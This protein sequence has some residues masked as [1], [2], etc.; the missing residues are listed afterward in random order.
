MNC[1]PRPVR[2]PDFDSLITRVRA[3]YEEMP[4][5][6]LTIPQL[7]RLCGVSPETSQRIVASLVADHFLRGTGSGA[8][9]RADAL[10]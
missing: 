10:P 1:A 8:F 2:A 4:G 3:E 5:L 9:G 7:S 6:W